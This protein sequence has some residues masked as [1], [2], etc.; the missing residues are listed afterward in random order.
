LPAPPSHVDVHSESENRR[1]PVPSWIRA[2]LLLDTVA[3]RCQRLVATIVEEA[4]LACVAPEQRDSVTLQLY[5]TQPTYYPGGARFRAG[6]FGWERQAIT[7]GVFPARG[8]ILVGGAG[9]GREVL[10]LTELGYRVSA[11]EPAEALVNGAKAAVESN[12]RS[13]LVRGAYSD[14]VRAADGQP[15][16][17][18]DAVKPPIDGV[19][20]GWTSF[21]HV[22][23][24]QDRLALLC[25]LHKLAPN[26]PVLMSFFGRASNDI[27][28]TRALLR[29]L[30]A[31]LGCRYRATLG[32]GFMPW[33]GFYYALTPDEL[34]S[35]ADAAGYRI[36]QSDF[37]SNS[38][39]LLVPK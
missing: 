12:G 20:L 8:H 14:L 2:T 33:A 4:L 22:L 17:L 39:A 7:G 10:A 31:R 18:G 32:D 13:R 11:F 34:S 38:H 16:P 28:R 15:S 36:L 30:F 29:R 19:I 21:S 5:E 37:Q 3:R 25:A 26:A 1:R 27:G 9:G 23:S 6:L 24:A 35:L